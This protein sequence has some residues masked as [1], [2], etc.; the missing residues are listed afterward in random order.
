MIKN[1]IAAWN[2]RTAKS[3]QYRRLIAEI[4][5]LNVRDLQELRADPTEMRRE[6]WVS[7]YGR[8]RA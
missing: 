8:S 3:R 6:A 1:L 5:T 2:E 4:E 7:V